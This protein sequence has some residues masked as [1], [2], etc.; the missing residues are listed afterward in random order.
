MGEKG[1]GKGH[2]ALCCAMS[3]KQSCF[4]R[5]MVEMGEIGRESIFLR[6]LIKGTVKDISNYEVFNTILLFKSSAGSGTPI[7]GTL[8]VNSKPLLH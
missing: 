8:L 6:T 4:V 3:D 7:L 1:E 2:N 5:E